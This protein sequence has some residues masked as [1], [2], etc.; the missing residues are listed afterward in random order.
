MSA[1]EM[2]ENYLKEIELLSKKYCWHIT[3]NH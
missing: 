3:T 2:F 1:K